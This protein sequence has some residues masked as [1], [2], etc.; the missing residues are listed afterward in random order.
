MMTRRG[1]IWGVLALAWTMAA[2]GFVPVPGSSVLKRVPSLYNGELSVLEDSGHGTRFLLARSRQG[3]VVQSTID[4]SH[5]QD[6]TMGYFQIM[7][8][9][10][11]LHPKPELVFNMGL[12]GGAL[13]RFHL[14]KYPKS[15]IVSAEIDPTVIDLAKQ[16]FFVSDSRHRIL[17]GDGYGVLKAQPGQYDV[18][19]VDTVTPKEG[20]KAFIQATDLKALR[21]HLKEGGLIVANLGESKTTESFSGVEHGYRQG[22]AH[23]IRVKSPMPLHDETPDAILSLVRAGSK[24]RVPELLPSYFV[25]VGDSGSLSCAAFW[26]LYQKWTHA[27]TISAGWGSKD[28]DSGKVQGI[29]TDL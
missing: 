21:D 16:F 25:V 22:F 19:W 27:K 29:C 9:L 17:E 13:P 10:T 23:G 1:L 7:A 20:P 24:E 12:G 2:T 26:T 5:K 18:I 6:L 28:A 3:L 4:L 14:G 11:G 8:L 15:Q